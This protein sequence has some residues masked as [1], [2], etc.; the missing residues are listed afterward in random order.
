MNFFN[1]IPVPLV[2]GK[3]FAELAGLPDYHNWVGISWIDLPLE[4]LS[5]VSPERL[6]PVPEPSQ[7]LLMVAGLAIITVWKLRA[8]LTS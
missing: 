1:H 5:V 6:P 7:W 4:I 2:P 3:S 8:K